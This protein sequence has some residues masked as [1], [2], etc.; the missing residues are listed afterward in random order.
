MAADKYVEFG[1]GG[2][3]QEKSA[4]NSSGG[5]GDADKIVALDAS[6]KINPNMIDFPPVVV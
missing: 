4:I 1:L 5:V 2:S 3:L 6:G